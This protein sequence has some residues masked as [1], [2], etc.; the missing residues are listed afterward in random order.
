MF[1]LIYIYNA[2][3]TTKTHF[4]MFEHSMYIQISK[5][6]PLLY[7]TCYITIKIML[8]K[9]ITKC[10]QKKINSVL[11]WVH[12]QFDQINVWPLYIYDVN[13]EV[14]DITTVCLNPCYKS[15]VSST[16][17]LYSVHHML[18]VYIITPI[19]YTL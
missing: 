13:K 10:F 9:H 11:Y 2:L 8:Y 12:N 4:H 5:T 19:L 1:C 15:K 17:T 18:T 3:Y 14:S 7:Y 16:F 6:P